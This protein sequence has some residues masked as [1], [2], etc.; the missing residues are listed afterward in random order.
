MRD[1]IANPLRI[2]HYTGMP[3]NIPYNSTDPSQDGISEALYPGDSIEQLTALVNLL[4]NFDLY[5]RSQTAVTPLVQAAAARAQAAA[6]AAAGAGAG[7]TAT[8]NESADDPADEPLQDG[9]STQ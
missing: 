1:W 5:T 2:L 7:G 3:K 4:V 8:T 6:G 9:D